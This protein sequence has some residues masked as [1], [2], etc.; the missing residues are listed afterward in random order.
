MAGERTIQR[1]SG[2]ARAKIIEY[3]DAGWDDMSAMWQAIERDNPHLYIGWSYMLKIVREWRV[4]KDA[5][6][7]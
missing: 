4:A 7:D 5:A 2:T 1:R 6:H 3:L